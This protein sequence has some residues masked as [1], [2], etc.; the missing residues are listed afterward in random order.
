MVERDYTLGEATVF[1]LGSGH[2]LGARDRGLAAIREKLKYSNVPEPLRGPRRHLH[3]RGPDVHGL[4][5]LL[6]DPALMNHCR[7]LR[8][9]RLHDRDPGAGAGADGAP[10][11][12]RSRAARSPSTINDDPDKA[13]DLQAGGTLLGT[14]ADQ[15]DLRPLG[16]RREGQLRRLHAQG[17]RRRRLDP[18]HRD[19]PHQ[20]RRSPRRAC[21]LS[22]QVKVKQDM[23]IEVEPEVLDVKKWKCKVRS[24]HNVATFIKEL[25][26]ELPARRGSAL[27]RRRLHPDRVPP[28]R[29]P[30]RTSTSSR[31]TAR[32]GTS[33]TSGSTSRR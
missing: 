23:E 29:S 31:S 7:I 10:G 30:T 20:P 25:I 22:C 1:G 28:T 16:L 13:E 5:G 2:R 8:R 27:P 32:T 15:Q 9:D 6:R 33:S 21:R 3:R 17:A 14:L 11:A 4:H 26:L 18:A 24:N 19:F 12:A